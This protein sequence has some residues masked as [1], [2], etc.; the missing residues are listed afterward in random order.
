MNF[1]GG[2]GGL[3]VID[4]AISVRGLPLDLVRSLFIYIRYGSL[5]YQP[6]LFYNL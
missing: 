1:L 2:R 5:P 4:G 3:E 6:A